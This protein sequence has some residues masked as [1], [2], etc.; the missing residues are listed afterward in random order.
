MASGVAA[1][2]NARFGRAFRFAVV[3]AALLWAGSACAETYR[4]VDDHGTINFTEDPGRIPA[5][6]RKRAKTFGVGYVSPPASPVLA[7]SDAGAPLPQ[8]ESHEQV[9]A[10][11]QEEKKVFGDREG[12]AWRNEFVSIRTDLKAAESL[13]TDTRKQLA[14][15]GRMSRR[16]YLTLQHSIRN[17]EKQV[18]GLRGKLDLLDA[19]ATKVRVPEDLR[20]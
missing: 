5:K 16:E 3:A 6:Y 9:P 8:S 2:S 15:S 17:I 20:R 11:R 19:A 13:L 14:D 1:D 7:S 12:A 4:W 18:L 10:L